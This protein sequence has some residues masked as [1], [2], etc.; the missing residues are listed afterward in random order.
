MNIIDFVKKELNL[1]AEA[2][3]KVADRI[4]ENIEKAIELIFN[5]QGKVVVT[6]MGKTGIIGRKIASTLSS[7]GTTSIFLHAAE[8]IHGDLGILQPED[9]VL[10]ISNSGNTEELISIIPFIKFNKIPIIAFTGNLDSKLAKNAD[11]I[12]DCHVAKEFE[13]FGLV[14]TASTTVALAVGDA[15]AV[16][17]LKKRDFQESDFA[18][19]HPGGTIGKKLLLRVEELMHKEIP[20]VKE[21]ETMNSAIQKMLDINIGGTIVIDNN[22]KLVGIITDGDLKRILLKNQQNIMDKTVSET[23]TK[24]PKTISGNS[25][26]VD[27]LN[28]MED[29]NITLLPVV[30]EKYK[31]VGVLQMHDLIKAGVVG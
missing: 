21:N 16:A 2:I 1:E 26:A 5:C 8:G 10:A 12:I 18:Q 13:P 22:D 31:P 3:Q 24:D 27:A 15:I 29:N 11:L 23:M 19:F 20:I 30:D 4:D 6:G 25:L 7:T 17:L 9:V 14:P 28:L